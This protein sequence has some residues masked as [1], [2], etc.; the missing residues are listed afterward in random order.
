MTAATAKKR[1]TEPKQPSQESVKQPK[2]L[3]VE[4]SLL[5][6]NIAKRNLPQDKVAIEFSSATA[7]AVVK[8]ENRILRLADIIL[9][10]P[11]GT[12]TTERR[13]TWKKFKGVER[14]RSAG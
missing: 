4:E 10:N 5:P 12:P 6:T 1:F 11:R 3:W 9:G 14:R 2:G 8:N 7:T 13:K